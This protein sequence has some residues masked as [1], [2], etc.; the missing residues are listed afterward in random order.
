MHPKVVEAARLFALNQLS[1]NL[2]PQIKFHDLEHTR[3]VVEAALEIG[4]GEGVH[5]N[6]LRILEIAAWF[7]DLGYPQQADGHEK[8][9]AGMARE[10]LLKRDADLHEIEKVERLILSTDVTSEPKDLLEKI[11][12][13]AD[14]AHLGMKDS[15]LRSLLLREEKEAMFGESYSDTEW[16]QINYNFFKNHRYNT[17][18][19]RKKFGPKKEEYLQLMSKSLI[20]RANNQ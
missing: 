4:K 1:S 9:G 6:D 5:D 20:R 18:T 7:H 12:R 19:A 13:D 10:F 11:I 8:I 15:R 2:P 14:M 17:P 3:T 16:L